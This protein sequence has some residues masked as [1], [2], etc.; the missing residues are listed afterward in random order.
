MAAATDEDLA[1][2][3]NAL[4]HACLRI[5]HDV[6]Q[7]LEQGHIDGLYRF[8]QMV[9]AE[10]KFINK[11]VGLPLKED[12][13]KSSNLSYLEAV[14]KAMLQS[15]NVVGVMK[16]FFVSDT[17]IHYS[18]RSRGIVKVDVVAENGL[19]WIRVNARNAKGLRHDIAGLE[20]SSSGSSD[21]GEEDG[22]E[23]AI[24]DNLPLF[25]KAKALMAS[26]ERHLVH[27]QKPIVVYAFM[28]ISTGDDP[29]VDEQI[30]DKLPNLGITVYVKSDKALSE[31]Y[32]QALNNSHQETQVTTDKLNLDVSTVM[33]VISEM[34]HRKGITPSMVR[35]EALELQAA[36]ELSHPLLPELAK[37][38]DKKQLFVT[39]SAMDKLNTIV[40]VVGGAKE[41]AR[42]EY[43]LGKNNEVDLWIN[44]PA[45]TSYLRLT[46]MEDKPTARFLELL[47]PPQG[48]RYKRIN[49]G[50][51]IRS[52]FNEFHVNVF[53]TGDNNRMTTVTSISWM[54]RALAD[55]GLLGVAIVEHE[56]RSLAEQKIHSGDTKQ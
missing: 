22:Q 44:Y 30:I 16:D 38:L 32:R 28:R 9:T 7:W 33:A 1:N 40:P 37:I 47:Q 8:D 34:V 13:V 42:F 54:G 43:M 6:D 56:P 55:A 29:Y 46:I 45:D 20:E 17:P 14:H 19:V 10:L 4:R 24:G 31:V 18:G 51:R 48:Q 53:G 49:N 27:F 15:N 50:R 35:G 52:K 3:V 12:Q 36:H 26:A 39:Q 41:R 2:K 23:G 25:R 11:L 5:K 21:D